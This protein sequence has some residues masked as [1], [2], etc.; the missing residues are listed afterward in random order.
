MKKCHKCQEETDRLKIKNPPICI[1][2]YR[3]PKKICDICGELKQIGKRNKDNTILCQSC[4]NKQKPKEI[5]FDCG[6]LRRVNK[7]NPDGTGLC[8]N[9]YEKT[10]KKMD[11]KFDLQCKLRNR[12]RSAFRYY[13]KTGKI[14]L[15]NK[16]GI[17][18]QAIIEHL[19]SCPGKREEYHI[20]HIFPLVAFDFDNLNHIKAAFAPKNHQWLLKEENLKKH[21]NYNKEEFRNYLNKYGDNNVI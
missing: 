9:C 7:R 18:Y 1:K 16:Y 3:S 15:S 12:V 20:D 5:C 14:K 19:G 2:C 21:D 10:R 4:Y 13:S 11:Y 8:E 6:K 17:N